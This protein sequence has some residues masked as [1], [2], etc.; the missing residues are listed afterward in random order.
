MK[1]PMFQVDAFTDRVF[2]G[3][4]AAVCVLDEWPEDRILQAVAAE[5]NLS[6]TA[7]LKEREGGYD[8]RWFTPRTEID[9]AGHPTLAAAKVVFDFLKPGWEKV[10]FDSPGG[11]LTVTLEEGGFLALDFPSRPGR[12]CDPPRNLIRGLGAEPEETFLARD[13]LAVF[14]TEEEVRAIN[15]D[16]AALLK[17]DSMGVIATA[18]G[19]DRDFVSRFFAPK[20]GILE[21]P[22]TGS[23]HCTLIP[24]WSA[25]LGKKDLTARQVSERTGEL[26]CRDEGERV[27]MAG[28]AVLY[29]EGSIHI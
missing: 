2:R 15:P 5:N 24:Y 11:P 14:E 19:E 9:L 29:L 21:D 18:P 25:R 17:L 20:V 7:Y 23:A 28:Q 1:I 4:P 16:P 10:C 27:V 6:E 22:V 12:P 3:N 13:H 26:R 8:L